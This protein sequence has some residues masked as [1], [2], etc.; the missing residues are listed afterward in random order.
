MLH[1]CVISFT[2]QH[3]YSYIGI[4]TMEHDQC[5]NAAQQM[6]HRECSSSSSTALFTVLQWQ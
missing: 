1:W 6:L 5:F 2:M 3:T 4:I